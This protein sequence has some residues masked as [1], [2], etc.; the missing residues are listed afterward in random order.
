MN[1]FNILAYIDPMSGAI[2]FQ[3]IFAFFAGIMA[4]FRHSIF[5]RIKRIFG[6]RWSSKTT[7]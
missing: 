1:T 2:V 4:F 5:D 6:G 7:N 3:L